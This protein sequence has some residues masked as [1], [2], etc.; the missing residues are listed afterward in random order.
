[1]NVG[2]INP[3]TN[4]TLGQYFVTTASLTVVTVWIIV[5]FQSRHMFPPGVPFWKR[6]GWPFF[7]FFYMYKK[8]KEEKMGRAKFLG[9]SVKPA[10]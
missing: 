4:G 6:L 2:V 3:G 5:A 7:L 1:M 9:F 10:V 8:T